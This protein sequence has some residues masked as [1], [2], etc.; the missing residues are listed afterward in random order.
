MA[1]F[2]KLGRLTG[3][4]SCL[5]GGIPA[6][7]AVAALLFLRDRLALVV[8]G[9]FVGVLVLIRGEYNAVVI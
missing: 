6:A 3:R 9:G 7:S 2:S 1:S 8:I 4:R 5:D